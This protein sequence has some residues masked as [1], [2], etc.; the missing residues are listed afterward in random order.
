MSSRITQRYA[1]FDQRMANLLVHCF[2]SRSARC[3]CSRLRPCFSPVEWRGGWWPAVAARARL[4]GARHTPARARDRRPTTT[5][6][7]IEPSSRRSSA[8][9]CCYHSKSHSAPRTQANLRTPNRIPSR[10]P[11][12]HPPH[13]AASSSPS[14]SLPHVWLRRRVRR[15]LRR[16]VR[17]LV[18]LQVSRRQHTRASHALGVAPLVRC[19]LACFLPSSRPGRCRPSAGVARRTGRARCCRTSC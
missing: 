3:R 7:R 6:R 2:V 14:S 1:Q 10:P 17:R 12:S 9:C 11:S 18:R 4:A 16:V 13:P 15:L 8:R 19:S 5:G